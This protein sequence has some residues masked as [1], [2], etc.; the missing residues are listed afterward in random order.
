MANTG[1][2]PDILSMEFAG[3]QM[4][5]N[6]V[7]RFEWFSGRVKDFGYTEE[8]YKDIWEVFNKYWDGA[9]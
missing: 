6:I 2:P 3:D 8:R 7:I 9:R 5:D 1:S 4:G